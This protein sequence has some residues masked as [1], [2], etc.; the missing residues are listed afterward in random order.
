MYRYEDIAR[1]PIEVFSSSRPTDKFWLM[2]ETVPV[3]SGT[4]PRRLI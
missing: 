3:V 2:Q 4:S 1:D